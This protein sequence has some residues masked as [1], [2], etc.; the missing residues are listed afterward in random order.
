MKISIR[1]RFVAFT[2]L[3]VCVY[4]VSGAATYVAIS[5]LEQS[6]Q[7]SVRYAEAIRDHMHADMMHD[8]LRG[9]VLAVLRAA[10][11]QDNQQFQ[12]AVEEVDAHAKEFRISLD[13]L[14]KARLDAAV[15]AHIA[16]VRP[17]LDA[18]ADEAAK[19]ASL[20]KSD[21]PAA[22][23]EM[24]A[25]SRVFEELERAMGQ[26]GDAI[27]AQAKALAQAAKRRTGWLLGSMAAGL[28]VLVP[29]I[30]LM[31]YLIGNRILHRVARL[32][33]FMLELASS[34]ADL[35]KRINTRSSDELGTTALAF[36]Q[37][38]NLLA[39]L[40]GAV[41]VSAG[42]IIATAEK[43]DDSSV[44]IRQRSE[45]QADKMQSTVV[46]IESMKHAIDAIA[47][48]AERVG[49]LVQSSEAHAAHASVNV[50]NVLKTINE[51]EGA[52]TNIA[53]SVAEF[54]KS[55]SEIGSLTK[56]VREIAEQTNLL[57]LNAAIEAA[58]AGEQGRGFAVV[59]DEVRK[60]AEKSAQSAVRIDT[61][62][63]TLDQQ[64][65]LVDGAV[66]QGLVALKASLD[67]VQGML[68]SLR[69][70]REATEKANASV[71]EIN[72]AVKE[73]ACSAAG[74]ATGAEAM[75]RLSTENHTAIHDDLQA[76]KRLRNVANDLCGTMGRFKL[77]VADRRN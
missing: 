25:F 17:R 43:L 77:A 23:A 60:L 39:E 65:A 47:D 9:D 24:N 10:A 70:A 63:G 35:T 53:Q 50:D 16:Q 61:V 66:H 29:L 33:A 57:A 36:N 38:M 37:F 68:S 48:G 28:A 76:V 69:Q 21:L 52:V 49:A 72:S 5:G 11:K 40:V 32:R 64:S 30:V 6:N 46:E 74:I 12:I 31:A 62:T 56:Q 75:A 59:A 14:D 18:Y 55:T 41:R 45:Q 22:E 54:V 4:L 27:E 44:Q 42:S 71:Q 1:Q 34:E 67:G 51:V 8:A 2:A 19:I 58:R 20:A 73:Q 13:A 3:V 26:L 7:T 15:V